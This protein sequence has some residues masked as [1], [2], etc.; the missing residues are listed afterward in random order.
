MASPFDFSAFLL[1]PPIP[2][3]SNGY[4][5]ST[6]DSQNRQQYHDPNNTDG[7]GNNNYAS[8]SAQSYA[9]P[10]NVF[11]E[12]RQDSMAQSHTAYSQQQRNESYQPVQQNHQSGPMYMTPDQRGSEPQSSYGSYQPSAF[13]NF[14]D[15]MNN[16]QQMYS[17]SVPSTS[18]IPGQ[19]TSNNLP[20]VAS[21][22]NP[23]RL[24]MSAGTG[25][26]PVLDERDYGLDPSAFSNVTFQMPSFLQATSQPG[27][28]GDGPAVV[29]PSAFRSAQPQ[30]MSIFQPG[31]LTGPTNN[32]RPIS[33]TGTAPPSVLQQTAEPGKLQAPV[34]HASGKK[35]YVPDPKNPVYGIYGSSVIS[36]NPDPSPFKLALNNAIQPSLTAPPESRS[37]SPDFDPKSLGL[38][39]GDQLFPQALPGLY[40]S[41][42]FDMLGVLARV[43]ARPNPQIN[44]GPVDTSCSFLVVDARRYDMPIVFA[45][46]TFSKLTG[47]H[48]VS[49]SKALMCSYCQR[50]NVPNAPVG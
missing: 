28:Y 34:A 18:M 6:N 40:S 22:S 8:S 43:V 46:D 23:K 32:T 35:Q 26:M 14:Q 44:I 30:G 27:E 15:P 33:Q 5:T 37:G 12:Q 38:P 49:C 9:P 29:D 1:T 45:S 41:S 48:N 10:N 3:Y 7:R 47:Y 21:G 16:Q 24:S 11:S 25:T 17:S 36:V 4:N 39:V 31:F 42:G 13:G 2:N 50:A 20:P 19:P